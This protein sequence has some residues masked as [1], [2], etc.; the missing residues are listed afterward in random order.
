MQGGDSAERDCDDPVSSNEGEAD[1]RW[2][3][4]DRDGR[5]RLTVIQPIC[6][7]TGKEH[8]ITQKSSTKQPCLVLQNTWLY[9]MSGP[10]GGCCC[11]GLSSV[12]SFRTLWCCM[13]RYTHAKPWCMDECISACWTWLSRC[14]RN[15]RSKVWLYAVLKLSM[16][17]RLRWRL[18]AH[19]LA[20]TPIYLLSIHVSDSYFK[21][22]ILTSIDTDWGKGHACQYEV[23]LVKA[24]QSRWLYHGGDKQGRVQRIAIL[25]AQVCNNIKNYRDTH[26][27]QTGTNV[28]VWQRHLQFI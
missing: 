13:T 25:P 11:L 24:S 28:Y 21:L 5:V 9:I 26:W 3:G 2:G 10:C 4:R 16:S 23:C 7:D 20:M 17:T 1:A 22:L 14:N 6:W 27:Q 18:K 15:I 8:S 19:L 12:S